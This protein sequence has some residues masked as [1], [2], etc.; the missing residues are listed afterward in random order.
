M[1]K[2]PHGLIHS[3]LLDGKGGLK[4][5]EPEA[6]S[7]WEMEHGHLWLHFDFT[8]PVAIDWIRKHSGLD[9][10]VQDALLMVESRPRATRVGNGIL[11]AF[12]GVNLHPE[13]TP[14]DMVGIRLWVEEHR[15]VSTV[16]RR[17]MSVDD[18]VESLMGDNGA[19]G[20][21]PEGAP[22]VLVELAAKL[23]SR[24]SDTVDDLED[25]I[26]ELEEVVLE[27][28]T[29]RE[30][31]FSL[32]KLRRQ[33]IALRRYLG[34]Q[35]EALSSLIASKV[36]WME[37]EHRAELRETGD[38]LMQ[39]LENLDA[40]R[41]R[42][43]VTQ[44]EVQSRL[45]EQQNIRMYVL[46]IVSAVFLPLGFLTGLLGINVG[47]IPGADNPYSFWIFLGFLVVLVGGQM[48]WFRFRKWF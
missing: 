23:V 40:V 32:A 30:A 4:A 3:S 6:L 34:P 38:R 25:K 5:F 8:D 24:M 17:L 10:V 39:H 31:R 33:V 19:N 35:R 45:A 37:E 27:G 28:D 9:D 14:D 12:R 1:E 44:E 13:S 36:P 11:V 29:E 20:E 43:A 22:E 21:G 41:E 16:R 2:L 7:E 47:G 46:S 15:I 42:A 48:V 18:V 26:A